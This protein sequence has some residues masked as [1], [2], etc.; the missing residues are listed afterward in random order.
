MISWRPTSATERIHRV[1][2]ITV[3]RATIEDLGT[4]LRFE[5]GVVSAERP[6]DA[7]L[8]EGV[9]HYYDI[10]NLLESDEALF[11]VAESGRDVVGCGFARVDSAKPYMKHSQEAYLGLMYV[12]PAHRR[13][14]I[15][16]MIMDSLKCWC[17]SRHIA[18]IRLE[19]YDRNLSAVKAYEKAGFSSYIV[20]MRMSLSDE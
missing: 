7:S 3:R 12:D 20:E 18:E 5:Q 16:G 17:R 14:G 8:R 13:L 10:K 15:N 4:L 6:Y 19:V 2:P 9:V 1:H 11:M